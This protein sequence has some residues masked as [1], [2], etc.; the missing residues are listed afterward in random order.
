LEIVEEA[1]DLLREYSAGVGVA[2]FTES[3]TRENAGAFRSLAGQGIQVAF[4]P[5]LP[6]E[7]GYFPGEGNIGEFRA[8]V[9]ELLGWAEQEGVTPAVLAVDHELPFDQMNRVLRARPAMQPFEALKACAANLDFQRYRSAKREMSDLNRSVRSR[10]IRTLAACLPWVVLE[11]G[12]THEV[13]QDMTETPVM[14]VDWDIISPMLYV[15]MLTGMTGGLL[16]EA[17][18]N[19]LT[20][21]ICLGLRTAR[22]GAAGVSLG[23]T[24]TGVFGDEPEF[25]GPEGLLVGIRAALAAGIRDISIYNLEG[26]IRRSDPRMWFEH[27]RRARPSVPTRSSKVS[28]ALASARAVYPLVASLVRLLS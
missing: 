6:R 13:L 15:S 24:G 28:R 9:D 10:G 23:V 12:G 11:S 3:M 14:S 17:D 22:R 7:R 1:Q 2:V 8:L 27:I 5:L 19:W 18:A 4:W 16:S 21:E 26:T 20:Y 25:D